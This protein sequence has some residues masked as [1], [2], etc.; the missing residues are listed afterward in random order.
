MKSGTFPKYVTVFDAIKIQDGISV[1]IHHVPNSHA[2]GSL[3]MQINNG[4]IF[5]GDALYS[6]KEGKNYVYNAQLLKEEIELLKNLPGKKVFSDHEERPLKSK[7]AVIR[8]LEQI[9]EK[10]EKNDAYIKVG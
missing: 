1:E 7:D 5:I 4:H 6:K 3:L 9:Y 2:K 10:R 8:F